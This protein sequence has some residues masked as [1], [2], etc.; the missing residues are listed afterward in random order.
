MTDPVLAPADPP[1]RPTRPTRPAEPARPTGIGWRVLAFATL[2]GVMAFA[3]ALVAAILVQLMTA[4]LAAI[5]AP[6]PSGT[7]LTGV[8]DMLGQI[9]PPIEILWLTVAGMGGQ[10][11]IEA[12]GLFGVTSRLVGQVAPAL[13]LLST[14]LASGW[15]AFRAERRTQLSAPMIWVAAAGAGAVAGGL[16]T[17]ASLFG[18]VAPDFTFADMITLSGFEMSTISVM[19]FFGPLVTVAVSAA[20]GRL[21]ART[22]RSRHGWH[23]MPAWLGELYDYAAVLTVLFLPVALL[24]M[25]LAGNGAVAGWPSGFGQ[26]TAAVLTLGHLGGYVVSGGQLTGSAGDT[27]TLIGLGAPLPWLLLLLALLAAVAA[28][29]LIAGRRV[30]RP[31]ATDRFWVLPVATAAAAVVAGLAVGSGYLTGAIDALGLSTPITLVATPA[32]WSYLLALVWGGVVEL[33]ARTLGPLLLAVWPGLARVSLGMRPT[34][35]AE[36]E[37]EPVRVPA[38][39]AATPVPPV[40]TISATEAASRSTAAALP[41]STPPGDAI[42][43]RPPSASPPSTAS[44]ATSPPPLDPVRR[45]RVIVGVVVGAGILVLAIGGAVVVSVLRTTVFS[46][47]NAVQ[48]YVDDIAA[49]RFASAFAASAGDFPGNTALVSADDVVLTSAVDAVRISDPEQ[50]EDYQVVPVSFEV[51]GERLSGM[52]T[53]ESVGSRFLFFDDWR[54]ASGLEV[55]AQVSGIDATVGGV[56]V[57]ARDGVELIAYPGVYPV[58]PR[59][60]EWETVTADAL[61]VTDAGGHLIA[62]TAP[63]AALTAEVQRQVDAALD[64]CAA[65]A[66][67]SPDGCPMSAF[68]WGDVRDVSWTITAYPDV[69][70]VSLGSFWASGGR[71]VASYER[72]NWD[73]VW[74]RDES[75]TSLWFNGD[76]AIDDRGVTVTLE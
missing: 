59:I 18:R 45:R 56:A 46:P 61:T 70:V 68:V 31:I 1:T 58:E 6:R 19:S 15:W 12:D 24:V 74:E 7:D 63:S 57:E 73:D 52:V 2:G 54:V 67:L 32:P 39:S 35:A 5:T 14:V 53:L 69:E 20:V 43:S 36:P 21:S 38:A 48:G 29:V 65:S 34:M 42:D 76:I 64:A 51:A 71:A 11:V 28:A 8:G 16:A 41:A 40:P 60:S 62:Q 23:G 25:L 13:V 55:R 4:L 50:I 22:V 17:V 66:D 26:I 27:Y 47:Q 3:A 49:G 33:T 30:T 44:A 72:Q 37:P 9:A 10:F 75:E